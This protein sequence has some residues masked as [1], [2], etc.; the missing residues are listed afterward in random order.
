MGGISPAAAESLPLPTDITRSD[1]RLVLMSVGQTTVYPS[2]ADKAKAGA[3][4]EPWRPGRDGVPCFTV[5]FLVEALGDRPFARKAAVDLKLLVDG[6]PLELVNDPHGIYQQWFDYPVFQDFLDF[7]K[8]EVTDPAR[9]FIM[10]YARFGAVPD[11]RPF[12][13]VINA[14]FDDNVQ[15]FRFDSIRLQ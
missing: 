12:I 11:L 14:G 4:T 1:V 7:R 2:E 5:T 6:K 15:E 9:A 13:L 10:R 3:G 8:P